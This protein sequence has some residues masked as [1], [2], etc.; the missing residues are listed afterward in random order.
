MKPSRLPA[1]ARRRS[2]KKA[3]GITAFLVPAD[4]PGLRVGQVFDKMGL[5]GS[6]TGELVLEDV[7]IPESHRLGRSLTLS[8]RAA[9][10]A[11]L[12]EFMMKEF[13]DDPRQPY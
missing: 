2:R 7:N 4:A 13:F 10:N 6:P 8:A 5:H 9:D 1:A 12:E 3:A 11:G